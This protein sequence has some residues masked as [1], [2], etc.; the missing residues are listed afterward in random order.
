MTIATISFMRIRPLWFSSTNTRLSWATYWLLLER[1]VSKRLVTLHWKNI[2]HF[3]GSF[4]AWLRPSDTR[5]RRSGSTF[6]RLE[7]NKGIDMCIGIAFH[8]PPVFLMK[9]NKRLC[10]TGD[11]AFFPFHKRK[12]HRLHKSS[13]RLWTTWIHS[14]F[15][16]LY[17]ADMLPING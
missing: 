2:L 6:S 3:N 1:T 4:I 10:L 17:H 5:F 16:L 12:W 15:F 14:N 9:N 11:E 8:C 7:A 13:V